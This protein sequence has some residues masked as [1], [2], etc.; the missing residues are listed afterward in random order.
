VSDALRLK[1]KRADVCVQRPSDSSDQSQRLFRDG[2]RGR[3]PFPKC[4]LITLESSRR[5]SRR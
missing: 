2:C 3:G 1:M 4:L 5:G